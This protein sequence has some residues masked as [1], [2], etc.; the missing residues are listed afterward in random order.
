MKT[1]LHRTDKTSTSVIRF[2]TVHQKSFVHIEIFTP[3]CYDFLYYDF[4]IL[5]HQIRICG[6]PKNQSAER[7]E[8]YENAH[9]RIGVEHNMK[10]DGFTCISNR[11]KEFYPDQDGLYYG[12][13]IPGFLGGNDP[14]DGVE[15][16]ESNGG[17]PH[18]LYVTYGFTDLYPDD[19]EDDDTN[20]SEGTDASDSMNDENE[21]VIDNKR[22]EDENDTDHGTNQV[23]G[24]GFELTFR[25]KRGN[26]DTAPV[27]PINLLQN[28][29]RYVFSTGN[30]FDSGHYLNANGPIA[31]ETDTQLTCLGFLTDPELGTIDTVNGSI[32]FLEA[33]GITEDE[34]NALMCWNGKRFLKELTRQIPYGISDLSRTTLMRQPDFRRTWEQ[35]VAC[36]G[37]STG[38][39][40]L[41]EMAAR[42]ENSK[43]YLQLGAGHIDQILTLLR[44][45]IE[46]DRPFVLQCNETVVCFQCAQ[47]PDITTDEK[48]LVISLTL[49]S[50]NEICQLLK[51]HIG[52]HSIKTIPLT[53]EVV[54]THIRDHDG[55][56]V[57]TI[58]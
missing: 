25:L 51:P 54:P 27:W 36:D 45:R 26:E 46:K 11:I 19:D 41:P 58:E 4:N 48:A 28:L 16:W 47:Q 49:E 9:R 12:T 21:N 1:V 56:I 29:A 6:N 20:N 53:I 10:T 52:I 43:G 34:L 50:L 5:K 57:Q 23:S 32:V 18:W 17:C 44:A 40:Y 55:K 24:Y 14:L 35:G 38:V 31:L 22:A 37:S 39:L 8:T 13:L 42:L 3:L 30:T 15:I 33:I 2:V 7:I